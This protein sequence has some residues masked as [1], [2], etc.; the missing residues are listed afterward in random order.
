[1]AIVMPIPGADCWRKSD[2]SK[3]QQRGRGRDERAPT[4]P[5]TTHG[6]DAVRGSA[7]RFRNELHH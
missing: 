2:A 4:N 7:A 1:V 6:I 3:S 5:S